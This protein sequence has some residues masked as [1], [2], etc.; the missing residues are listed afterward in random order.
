[1]MA[2]ATAIKVIKAP[3]DVTTLTA[4]ALDACFCRFSQ[5]THSAMSIGMQ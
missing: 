5:K 1:M 3:I 4:Q 2:A